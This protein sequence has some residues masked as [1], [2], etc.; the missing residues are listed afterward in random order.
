MIG[1]SYYLLTNIKIHTNDIIHQTVNIIT[2]SLVWGLY[3][4]CGYVSLRVAGSQ[5]IMVL[6]FFRLSFSKIKKFNTYNYLF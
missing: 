5:I 6:F 1:W 4:V 2:D 3:W